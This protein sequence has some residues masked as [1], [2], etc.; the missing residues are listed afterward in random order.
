MEVRP[1][2][3]ALAEPAHPYTAALLASLPER[4]APRARL[5]AIGGVVPGP[6]DRPPGCVFA[7]RCFQARPECAARPGLAPVPGGV[8][9]CLFPLA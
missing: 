7:P 5:P 1:A 2:A 9:R 4:A 3:A 6:A 8:A